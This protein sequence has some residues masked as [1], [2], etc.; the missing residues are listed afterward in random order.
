MRWRDGEHKERYTLITK[1]ID[2]KEQLRDEG[3]H[4]IDLHDITLLSE[5]F[6]AD[7]TR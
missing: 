1:E 3:Y 6:L 4:V 5:R 7:R 2:G